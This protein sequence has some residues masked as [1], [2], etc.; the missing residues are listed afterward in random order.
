MSSCVEYENETEYEN[1][2]VTEYEN[3]SVTEYEN[4]SVTE[5]LCDWKCYLAEGVT[6]DDEYV[7]RDEASNLLLLEVELY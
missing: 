5:R 7:D 6:L 3:E 2:S 4:E 1:E